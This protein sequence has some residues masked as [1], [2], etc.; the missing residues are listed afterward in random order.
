L[1]IAAFRLIGAGGTFI[2]TDALHTATTKTDTGS[3]FGHPSLP[4]E[5]ELTLRELSVVDLMCEGKPN[6]VIAGRL[7]LQESTVKVHVRNIL[8]KL[9]AANRTQ[10]AFVAHRLR[11]YQAEGNSARYH[12]PDTPKR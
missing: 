4:E 2:P 1:A 10:A 7:N 8:R 9:N 6:K 11:S 12:W 3:E 5:L